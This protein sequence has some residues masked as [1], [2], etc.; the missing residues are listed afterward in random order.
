VA[1]TSSVAA[2][3][4]RL[5]SRSGSA[6]EP[7]PSV[8]DSP[9]A[10][11]A[12]APGAGALPAAPACAMQVPAGAAGARASLLETA[13]VQ[14]ACGAARERLAAA[15]EGAASETGSFDAFTQ[16]LQHAEAAATLLALGSNGQQQ[17]EAAG[18][19][20]GG[21]L[22]AMGA[23]AALA[24]GTGVGVHSAGSAQPAA[25]AS[26]YH[27]RLSSMLAGLESLEAQLAAG[28][29]TLATAGAAA[30]CHAPGGAALCPDAVLVPA[31]P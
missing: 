30:V 7:M 16:L 10:A 23:A 11:G 13:A 17:T 3:L 2:F 19:A 4:Q 14:D 26:A 31:Q 27:E 25:D 21:L 28:S 18:V 6:V 15:T 8:Q 24:A 20:C 12:P 29:S 9:A 1:H 5:T 22:P